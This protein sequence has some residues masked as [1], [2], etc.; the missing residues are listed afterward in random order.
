MPAANERS[1][2]PKTL[3]IDGKTYRIIGP[4]GSGAFGANYKAELVESE[5]SSKKERRNQKTYCIKLMRLPKNI[6][7]FSRR[8]QD[9][10][11]EISVLLH[12][13]S[14]P[15]KSHPN[16]MKFVGYGWHEDKDICEYQMVT[17]CIDGKPLQSYISDGSIWKWPLRHVV[18][19][20]RQIASGLA[21]LHELGIV[22]RD[23]KPANTM[24]FVSK[25][26]RKKKATI[27]DFGFASIYYH[28]SPKNADAKE[29]E[30]WCSR[31]QKKWVVSDNY[32]KGTPTYIAPELWEK[33]LQKHE[34]YALRASDVFA[35]GCMFYKMLSRENPWKTSPRKDN[36]R[37][38]L[39]EEIVRR[40]WRPHGG[41]SDQLDLS[42]SWLDIR[43]DLCMLINHMLA[44]DYRKRPS[45]K[46]VSECLNIIENSL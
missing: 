36:W 12:L 41:S 2:M 30:D 11:R 29:F 42:K 34:T 33:K 27:I 14:D 43:Q 45:M 6:D 44:Y 13:C 9:I 46:Q 5:R 3:K 31:F 25:N 40:S 24:L 16:I 23:I 32:W 4:L 35:T 26:G 22:H 38:E 10:K 39:C 28:K 37:D 19:V 15:K 18:H 1:K 20:M 21:F 17:E 8:L 7:H